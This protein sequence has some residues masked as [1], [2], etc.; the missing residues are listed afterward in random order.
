[1]S[2]A[3]QRIAGTVIDESG[4]A[5]IGVNVLIKGTSTGTV[6]DVDGAYV[7]DVPDA[8]TIVV[9]SYTGY[10]AEEVIVGTRSV[11]D[12]TMK[13]DAKLL[14]EVVVIGYGTAAKKDLVSSVSQVKGEA[15]ENQPVSRLDQAL[16]GRAAGVEVV[17]N[18][19]APGAQTTLRI[20]GTSSINGNNNPLFVVDGFIAGTGFDLNA[21]NVNDIKSIE[22][23]KDA[24]SLAIYGTRGAA[25]V[26]MITTK[27]GKGLPQGKPQIR[28]N[29]YYTTQEVANQIEVLGGTG[30]DLL[31]GE[32]DN[33]EL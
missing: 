5:L 10:A 20:R 16:Q 30:N 31:F 24:T 23:L 29:Q 28:L 18:S 32:L 33:D 7:L 8:S 26:V 6:T 19:G 27:D 25:G 1:M 2:H 14:D 22:I 11:I 17:S 21:L 3:Q 15:L 4:E 13:A 9:F 12:L